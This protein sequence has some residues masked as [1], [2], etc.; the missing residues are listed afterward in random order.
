MDNLSDILSH[1]DFDTP[2]EIMAIKNYVRRHYDAEVEVMMQQ[3]SIL[4]SARSASLI[5][6]L[7]L[8]APAI[9][10]IAQTEKSLVFRIK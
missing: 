7:R 10:K 5:G 1:K 9:K 3:R 6:T 8:N 4:I 2:Q